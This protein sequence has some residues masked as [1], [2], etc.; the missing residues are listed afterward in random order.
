MVFF[1]ASWVITAVGWVIHV[2]VDRHPDKRT[3]H[4]VLELFLEFGPELPLFRAELWSIVDVGVK[5]LQPNRVGP[6]LDAIQNERCSA[7][8]FPTSAKPDPVVSAGIL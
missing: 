3:G 6:N 8:S 5:G 4:R 7:V 2:F 1:A